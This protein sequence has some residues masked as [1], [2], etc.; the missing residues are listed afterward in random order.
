MTENKIQIKPTFY[1]ATCEKMDNTCIITVDR[2]DL[3]TIH[4][5]IVPV[6]TLMH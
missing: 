3:L 5:H 1:V 4:V 2:Q 6:D